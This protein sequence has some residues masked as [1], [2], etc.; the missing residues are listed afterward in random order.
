MAPDLTAVFA[1]FGRRPGPVLIALVGPN[2]AGKSTFYQRFLSGIKWPFVNADV[3]AKALVDAGSPAGEETEIMAAQLAEKR[4]LQLLEK[5]ESFVA[6][7]VFSDPVGAKVQMLKQAQDA[8]YE[9]VLVFV[10]LVSAE[11]SALRVGTRVR[12]GGHDVPKERIAARLERMRRNVN[13]ALPFVDLGLIVDNSSLDFP[14][15]PVAVLARG[16]VLKTYPP[17]PWWAAEVMPD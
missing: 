5:R 6:E 2:G 17:V 1:E 4:R 15:R 7:T 16:T 8:G 12:M 14:H 3:L 10:G 11:L 9:V 13:A